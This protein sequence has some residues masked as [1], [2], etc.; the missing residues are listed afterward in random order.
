MLDAI[1]R[2]ADLLE[3]PVRVGIRLRL[4]SARH[5]G[6]A[7]TRYTRHADFMSPSRPL[8]NTQRQCKR[9]TRVVRGCLTLS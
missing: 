7:C 6:S 8:V 5:T 9:M 3:E 4:S 2:A 1:Q